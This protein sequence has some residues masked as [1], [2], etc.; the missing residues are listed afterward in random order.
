MDY[1]FYMQEVD[2]NGSPKAG[3][4]KDLETDFIGLKYLK[5]EGINTIGKPKIYTEEYADSHNIRVYIPEDL[6]NETTTIS[7]TLLFIGDSRQETYDSFNEYV[8]NGFHKYWDTARNK[9][10][11][12][13]VDDEIKP[14]EDTMKGG[15]HY[16]KA[17]YKLHNITGKTTKV[18]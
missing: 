6:K 4:K 3:T 18:L 8:R 12:F 13:Y 1:K 9:S 2:K 17:T 14:T 10:F 5:A 16:I 15:M 7:L 11:T